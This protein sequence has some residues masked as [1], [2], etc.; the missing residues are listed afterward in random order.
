MRGS[1]GARLLRC[2]SHGENNRL[3]QRELA[4]AAV[5]TTDHQLAEVAGKFAC[6]VTFL[7][8]W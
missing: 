8:L 4:R 7:R 1:L 5:Y 3:R 2:L 6:A